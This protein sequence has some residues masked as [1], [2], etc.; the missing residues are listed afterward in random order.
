MSQ[1]NVN[2]AVAIIVCSA[3]KA[4]ELGLNEAGWIYPLAAAQSRHVVT[5]AQKEH[6]RTLPGTVLTGERAMA[7][8]C[9]TAGIR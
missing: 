6:L 4:R 8:A 9:L 5:L 2:Q 3:G 1:W 7:L